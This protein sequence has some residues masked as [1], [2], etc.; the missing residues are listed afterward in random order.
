MLQL[1]PA[2]PRDRFSTLSCAHV[3]PKNNLLAQ[4]VSMGPRKTEFEFKHSNRDNES[5]VCFQSL[6]SNRVTKLT[7]QLAELGAVITSVIGLVPDGVVVFVPS[8]AFLDKVKG[9]WQ[10]SG[11]LDRIA[12]RKQVRPVKADLDRTLTL[13]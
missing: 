4:V 8:Y 9:A 2:V 6:K 1:F 5:L 3:I 11:V 10:A 12:S 7:V 13:V